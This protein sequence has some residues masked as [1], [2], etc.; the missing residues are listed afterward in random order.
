M[1]LQEKDKIHYERNKNRIKHTKFWRNRQ[2]SFQ[3]EIYSI[4]KEKCKFSQTNRQGEKKTIQD[5]NLMD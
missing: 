4:L 2:V 3:S 1:K 5:Q